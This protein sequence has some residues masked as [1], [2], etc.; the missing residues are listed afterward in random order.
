MSTHLN[1]RRHPHALREPNTRG[2]GDTC[3]SGQIQ[4]DACNPGSLHSEEEDD[5]CAP[6]VIVL[7]LHGA[8]VPCVGRTT[9]LSP[10]KV[11]T[12]TEVRV[13]T[14]TLTRLAE[15]VKRL[16]WFSVSGCVTG[17][18]HD[19]RDRWAANIERAT[20]AERPEP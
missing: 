6:I 8:G 20:A 3:L 18:T 2:A 5:R 1:Q 13:D 16:G 7:E 14:L 10:S 11:D 4:R 19:Q 9:R 12:S 15:F 17:F